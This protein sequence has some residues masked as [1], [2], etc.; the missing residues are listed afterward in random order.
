MRAITGRNT[1]GS[2]TSRYLGLRFASALITYGND[3]L[4]EPLCARAP[5]VHVYIHARAPASVHGVCLRAPLSSASYQ[6]D[7][8]CERDDTSANDSDDADALH[9]FPVGS[10]TEKYRRSTYANR[11]QRSFREFASLLLSLYLSLR[12]SFPGQIEFL[13]FLCIH[14]KR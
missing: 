5:C 6:R 11:V 2:R 13:T 3:E 10:S 8:R 1:R 14:V 4:C 12:T 9:I 7:L